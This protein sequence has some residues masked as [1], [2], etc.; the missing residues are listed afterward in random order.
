MAAAKLMPLELAGRA[1]V[2]LTL[3]LMLSGTVALHWS[4]HRR[5]SIWPFVAALF[6]HNWIFIF[7]FLNY[8]FGVGLMLWG[9]AVW[10]ALADR[11]AWQRLIV[12]SLV[13]LA[14]YFAHMV[15]FGLYALALGGYELQRAAGRWRVQPRAALGALI[16]GAVPFVPPLLL[17]VLTSPTSREAGDRI[18]YQPEWYWKGFVVA[19]SFMSMNLDLDLLTAT[20]LLLAAIA[21]LL[22]GRIIFARE[23]LLGFALLA[24]G[25]LVMPWKMFGAVFVDARLPVRC[26]HRDRLHPGRF[27]PH[28]DRARGLSRARRGAGG[29]QPGDR[30]RLDRLRPDLRRL[31][32]GAGAGARQQRDPGG[33]RRARRR[34]TCP[35]GSSAGARRS[36]MAASMALLQKP[37][38]AV[39]T[40]RRRRQQ[41][42]AVARPWSGLYR[43]Q[44][45]NPMPV[46][47]TAS[48]AT[49]V[50]TSLALIDRAGGTATPTYLMLLYPGYMHYPAPAALSP[51]ADGPPVRALPGRPLNRCPSPRHPRFG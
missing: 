23:M 30:R 21:V 33:D 43:Y 36:S 42:I 40:W 32:A 10:L 35:N 8:L 41:P 34:A 50:D 6:L 29:A 1:F 13:A 27:H 47:S 26:S 20:M 17:F 24:I 39:N 18:K 48:L 37:V 9:L 11:P 45:Q 38:F 28:R 12:G 5:L 14:I 7:G 44:E 31:D 19:R 49:F 22:R 25:F 3:I 51:V 4:L 2:A 16:V 46:E 15:S